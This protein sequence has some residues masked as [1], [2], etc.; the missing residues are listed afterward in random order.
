MRRFVFS[1]DKVLEL[2]RYHERQWELKLAEVTGRI[3]AVER[4][5]HSWG[6]RRSSA[7]DY[8]VYPGHVD[9]RTAWAR[10]EYLTLIDTRVRELQTRLH[11]LEHER[12]KVRAS[13]LDASSA[14][15]ALTRLEERRRDEYYR[16]AAKDEHR[17]L[18][19]IGG[20]LTARRHDPEELHV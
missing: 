1:L 19:E 10:E 13:Y 14:R 7:V 16:E 2:R 20:M 5:I 11:A 4:E 18:D 12:S 6:A 3:V 17:V 8:R 9:M 15:K